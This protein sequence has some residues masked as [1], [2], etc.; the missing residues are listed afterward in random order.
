M[1]GRDAVDLAQFDDLRRE[2]AAALAAG[3]TAIAAA[4]FDDALALHA[5]LL[6]EFAGEA[7]V[8]DA[9]ARLATVHA[10]VLEGV[11]EAKL[12]LGLD[13]ELVP[14]LEAAVATHPFRERLRAHLARALY[15]GARQTDALRSL[16]D[17]R[18]I[19]GEEI[20]VEPGPELRQLEA[21]ILAQASHLDAPGRATPAEAP[22]ASRPL[23]RP[24]TAHPPAEL[25]GRPWSGDRPS[26]PCWST[27]PAGPRPA[28]GGRWW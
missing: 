27:P 11:F 10:D 18:R 22:G 17:A 16:A 6:P 7:W 19:L 2:A 3:D 14:P 28:P 8:A 21:D 24:G 15:R 23:A 25:T 1:A 26:W 20:G 9:A 13:S 4:R 5:P 12:K